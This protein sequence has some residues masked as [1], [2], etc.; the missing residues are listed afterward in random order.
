[1]RFTNNGGKTFRKVEVGLA[2]EVANPSL[3]EMI[4]AWS[5][6]AGEV[7][8]ATHAYAGPAGKEDASWTVAA[9]KDVRTRWV[10]MTAR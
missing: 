6:G 7:K 1:M 5:E 2:Y 3:V 9:G 4:Y 8:T 10:K